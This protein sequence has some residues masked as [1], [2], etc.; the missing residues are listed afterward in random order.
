VEPD[1]PGLAIEPIPALDLTRRFA[2]VH[3]KGVRGRRLGR[4]DARAA[5]GRVALQASVALSAEQVGGARACLERAIDHVKERIQ[6]GRPLGSFQ[7]V[8]H[9]AADAYGALELARSAA[10]W[11]WWVVAEDRPELAEAAHV[12]ASL[13]AEAFDRAARECIH[14]HGGIGFTWEHD[15]HLYLRRARTSQTL[16]GDPTAHR[17]A[18]AQALGIRV[19]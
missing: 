14:L 12:S 8:K 10:Y 19:R 18:L 11:A 2:H 15:A 3:C 13:A 4:G 6:F 1:A 17:A 5:L 9:R 16:F 7:A